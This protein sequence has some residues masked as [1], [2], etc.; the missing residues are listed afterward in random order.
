MA[1]EKRTGVC[2]MEVAAGPRLGAGGACEE[3]PIGSE[4]DFEALAAK[5]AALGGE[6]LV[7]AFDLLGVERLEPP[8]R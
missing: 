8:P 4:E 7:R 3:L 1:G 2:V 5:L 6:L